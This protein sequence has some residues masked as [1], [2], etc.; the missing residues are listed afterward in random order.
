MARGMQAMQSLFQVVSSIP[1]FI[2]SFKGAAGNQGAGDITSVRDISH[3]MNLLLVSLLGGEGNRGLVSVIS[4]LVPQ[5]NNVASIIGNPSAFVGKLNAMKATF[6]VIGQ[7]PQMIQSLSRVENI[8]TVTE[9]VANQI[10]RV[11]FARVATVVTDM[12]SHVNQLSASIRGIRPIQI[13]QS[14]QHL[15]DSI[16]LGSHGEYTIENRNFTINVNVTVKLDNDG[17]DAL[18]LGMLRRTGPHPT[19][20]T[21]GSLER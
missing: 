2:Q 16:G 1:R 5:V 7:I 8:A 4:T 19:R 3:T 9:N 17:L 20:I 10:E 14:L 15:G 18:E 6:D 13:E 12:V 21:H 11:Q